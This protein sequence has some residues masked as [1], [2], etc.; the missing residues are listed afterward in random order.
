MPIGSYC[1]W[2]CILRQKTMAAQATSIFACIEFKSPF[3]DHGG[4]IQ[5]CFSRMLYISLMAAATGPPASTTARPVT[6]AS[7]TEG[8]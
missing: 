1:D 5:S 8:W 2:P 4:V 6:I 3:H 7:A